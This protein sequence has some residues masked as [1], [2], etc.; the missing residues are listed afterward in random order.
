[1]KTK[2]GTAHVKTVS[3]QQCVAQTLLSVRL[4]G[5]DKSVCANQ[6]PLM[7]PAALEPLHLDREPQH[8]CAGGVESKPHGS[9]PEADLQGSIRIARGRSRNTRGAI[10][11]ELGSEAT[12]AVKAAWSREIERRVHAIDEG[13]VELVSWE[14]VRAELFGDEA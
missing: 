10:A 8:S 13:S 4:G 5:T 9:R 3:A 11:G 7:T 1:M 6:L 2:S 12:P 14:E